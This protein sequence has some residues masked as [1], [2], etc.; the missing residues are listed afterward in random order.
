[1]EGSGRQ[2]EDAAPPPWRPSGATMFRRFVGATA[3]R[4]A[5]PQAAPRAAGSGVAP[6][7]SK[8]HGVKRKPVSLIYLFD[9][10]AE[11][12]LLVLV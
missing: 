10:L 7:V 9:V 11:F 12:S 4:G 8:L 5:A 1:M 3:T 6:R 2:E